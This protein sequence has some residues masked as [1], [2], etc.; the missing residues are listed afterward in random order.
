M[1]PVE[2]SGVVFLFLLFLVFLSRMVR[3][4]AT[5]NMFNHEATE[6][7]QEIAC[8]VRRIS[9]VVC[10]VT[11]ALLAL[12]LAGAVGYSMYLSTTLVSAG[13][14]AGVVVAVLVLILLLNRARSTDFEDNF[15]R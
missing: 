5:R 6:R 7:T 4:Q 11:L 10:E 14:A 12:M 13:I 8:V 3:I 9:I 2:I 1:H 15:C